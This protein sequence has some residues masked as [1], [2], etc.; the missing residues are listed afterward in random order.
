MA[1]ELEQCLKSPNLELLRKLPPSMLNGQMRRKSSLELVQAFR[2]ER[3]GAAALA[4]FKARSSRNSRSSAFHDGSM[5]FNQGT[6]THS[7]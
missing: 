5:Q 1:A 2:D 3:L 6:V 7:E 4:V